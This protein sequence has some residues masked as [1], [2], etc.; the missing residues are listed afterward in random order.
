MVIMPTILPDIKLA[1][2]GQ[3]IKEAEFCAKKITL[4]LQNGEIAEITA[5]NDDDVFSTSTF[6]NCKVTRKPLEY[7]L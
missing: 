7:N 6:L 4:T 3:T 1:L 2:E 5:I